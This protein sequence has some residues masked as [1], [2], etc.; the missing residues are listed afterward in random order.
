MRDAA[1]RV[2][3]ATFPS[4][5]LPPSAFQEEEHD[6]EGPTLLI[7]GGGGEGWEIF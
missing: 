7:R 6:L 1:T 5:T 2:G 3:G 4:R